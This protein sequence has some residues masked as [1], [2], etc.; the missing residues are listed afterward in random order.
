MLHGVVQQIDQH[1]VDPRLIE[2]RCDVPAAFILE[3]RSR[4]RGT[5]FVQ[6]LLAKGAEIS[7]PGRH[8]QAATQPRLCVFEK[9]GDKTLHGMN[10]TTDP[11][12]R[13]VSR[14][15]AQTG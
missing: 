6:G 11:R 10:G 1:L 14:R 7:R 2:N 4:M 5:R 9:V 8:F 13:F 15:I 3:Q 12:H